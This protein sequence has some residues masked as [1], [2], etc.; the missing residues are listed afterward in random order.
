VGVH[1]VRCP[2]DVIADE[3][4]G[5]D[6]RIDQDKVLIECHLGARWGFYK[7]PVDPAMEDPVGQGLLTWRAL[8]LSAELVG[9]TDTAWLG[10]DPSKLA[11]GFDL[12]LPLREQLEDARRL[13][14]V[15]R[16]QRIKQG[17]MHPKTVAACCEE[18][19]RYLRLLD[20]ETARADS[21]RITLQLGLDPQ[22]LGA[23]W[24]E[25][26]ALVNGGYRRIVGLPEH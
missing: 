1:R 12:S 20:A 18:W 21:A 11:L 6:C 24:A 15:M 26:Q 17:L 3:A 8:P 14:A 9:H 2:G 23:V 10:G 19:T 22:S 7:F 4:G 5:T 16:R 25:T 13:L